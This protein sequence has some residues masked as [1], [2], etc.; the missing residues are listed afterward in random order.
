MIS[1]LRILLIEDLVSDVELV[2]LELG[3]AKIH[4]HCRVV[5]KEEDFIRE[6][7]DFQPDIILS[8][9]ALPQFNG[10]KALQLT[11]N[12]YP[13]LPFVL[14]TGS[15]NEEIAVECMKQGADDYVLKRSLKRLP[16]A[17]KNAMERR[18]ALVEKEEAED[19]YRSLFENSLDG[20]YRITPQGKFV[21][22]NPALIKM[23]GCDN[24]E[25]LFALEELAFLA[26]GRKGT[27]AF[28]LSVKGEQI[29]I[30]DN[31]REVLDKE[32]QVIYYEG[33]VRNI[34]ERKKAEEMVKF[35]HY[36]DSLTKLPNRML[37]HERLNLALAHAGLNH[38]ML[39]VLFLDLDRFKLVNDILGHSVGDQLLKGMAER[40]NRCLNEGDSVARTGGD[41]FALLISRVYQA[42]NVAKTAEKIMETL[43]FPFN[44][45]G[46]EVFSTASIGISLYPNDGTDGETLLK[47]SEAAMYRAK[48]KGGN[49]Y[50]FYTPTMNTRIL[51]RLTLENSLRR[52]LKRKEFIAYYQPQVDISTGRIVGMEALARWSSPEK[53]LIPPAKFIPLAEETDLIIPLGE[54]ILWMACAQNKAWQDAGFLPMRVAVNLSAR[55]FQQENLV[56][57]IA[58]ILKETGLEPQWLELEITESVLMQDFEFTSATLRDLRKMGVQ[59]SIDDFGT[60]YSSLNYLKKFPINTLKIDQSFIRDSMINSNDATIITAMII[61]AHNLNLTVTAEG[62]ETEEQLVFLKD[63]QCDKMQGYI[64]SPP[65]SAE[66]FGKMLADGYTVFPQP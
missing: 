44:L 38:Q 4:F 20:I 52:A 61:L 34:T 24:K 50:Q 49:C 21:D 53:G 3:R 33:I 29:W 15:T 39:A 10:L 16:V 37:F 59:I 47:N 14:V 63:H 60:G 58:Q 62:V 9:Y 36:H 17:L 65:V 18:K 31:S 23:L 46:E 66:K 45:G 32:G 1:K 51:E 30:E 55:Q 42:E 13:H 64:F 25:E 41:E 35:Q 56:K 48:E 27:K 28:P 8:D 12:L 54:I 40:L 19:R 5:M 57:S 11:R 22:A 7:Q 2:K 6:I 43:K 26:Y